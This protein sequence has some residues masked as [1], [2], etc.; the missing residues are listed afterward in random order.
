MIGRN[1]RRRYYHLGAERLQQ[2]H[3]FLGHLVRHREYA[4]VSAQ[5]RGNRETNTGISAGAFDYRP[6][7][8]EF[9]FSL[10]TLDDWQSDSILDGPTRIEELGFRKNRCANSTGD[11]VQFDER[12]P[13]N[14]LKDVVVRLAVPFVLH[15][16]VVFRLVV[17]RT[18]AFAAVG[19]AVSAFAVST[20]VVLLAVAESCLMMESPASGGASGCLK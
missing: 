11:M 16:R 2:P 9:S 8:L 1:C 13:P 15:Q 5:G 19:F 4:L 10:C 6:A 7:R 12:R 3:F 17:F 18:G 20:F 14:R